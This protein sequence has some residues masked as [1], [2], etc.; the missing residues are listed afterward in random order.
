MLIGRVGM[1]QTSVNKLVGGVTQQ[2]RS[3]GSSGAELVDQ[4]VV[5]VVAVR[6]QTCSQGSHV[7][8]KIRFV[9]DVKWM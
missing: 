7:N 8:Q 6:L 4:I 3:M 9:D 2:L 1:V 5:W